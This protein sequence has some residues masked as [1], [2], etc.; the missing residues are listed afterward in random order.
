MSGNFLYL[1]SYLFPQFKIKIAQIYIGD[2]MIVTH[3]KVLLVPGV[4]LALNI[5][6]VIFMR[7]VKE[8]SIFFAAYVTTNIYPY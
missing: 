8:D 4:Q 6:K 3:V 2:Q 7:L 5:C 1:L